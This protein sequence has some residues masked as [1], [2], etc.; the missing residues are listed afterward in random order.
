MPVEN[1]KQEPAGH[2]QARP[3]RHGPVRQRAVEVH[4]RKQEGELAAD[5]ARD[6]GDQGF[7]HH[8]TIVQLYLPI[9]I[10]EICPTRPGP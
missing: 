8:A 9:R 7:G 4:R 2:G 10:P 1:P 6:D 5:Q 3:H